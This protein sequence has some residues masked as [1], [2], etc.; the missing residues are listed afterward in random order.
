MATPRTFGLLYTFDFHFWLCACMNCTYAYL[1][2]CFYL[3]S[4]PVVPRYPFHILRLELRWSLFFIDSTKPHTLLLLTYISVRY[5]PPQLCS[6]GYAD[7][8][9]KPRNICTRKISSL[10]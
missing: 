3:F 2:L 10:K 4:P 9:P 8:H 5:I 7:P 1:C 6:C